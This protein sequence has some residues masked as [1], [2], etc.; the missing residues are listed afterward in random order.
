MNN[1]MRVNYDIV[2]KYISS[3]AATTLKKPVQPLKYP[4][5]DPGSVYDGNLWD[6]DSFWAVYGLNNMDEAVLPENWV[7][8]AR[9]NVFLTFWI[10]N[11]KTDTFPCLLKPIK[12]KRFPG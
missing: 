7:D 2:K 5:V 4:F 6:W 12:K 11:W 1:K 8:Y 3:I 9:G 10:I